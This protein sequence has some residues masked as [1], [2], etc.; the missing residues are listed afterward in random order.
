MTNP[1]RR[2][3]WMD[4]PR[5]LIVEGNADSRVLLVAYL[6]RLGYSCQACPDGIAALDALAQFQPDVVLLELVLPRL[7]GVDLAR[8]IRARGDGA[9]YVLIAYTGRTD[10]ESRRRAH[11]AGIDDYVIKPASLTEVLMAAE[12]AR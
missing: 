5:L 8:A 2:L 1:A 6:E 11:E 10:Q 9:A 7:S 4:R 3:F 12:R